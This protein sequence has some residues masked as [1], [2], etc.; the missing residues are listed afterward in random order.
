MLNKRLERKWD[1][2]MQFGHRE[3]VHL[4]QKTIDM[5][6]PREFVHLEQNLKRQQ[7]DEGKYPCA[8]LRILS[9]V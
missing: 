8:H 9:A 7:Q 3:R 6:P 4:A 2:K 5:E 1:E